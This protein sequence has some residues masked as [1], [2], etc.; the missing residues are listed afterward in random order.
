MNAGPAI[1]ASAASS[2]GE[3]FLQPYREALVACCLHPID[4]GRQCLAKR[5]ARHPALERGDTVGPPHRRPVVKLEPVAQ[6]KV[7]EQLVRGDIVI[8]YH[9]RLR[10]ELGSS[11]NSVWYTIYP[12]LRVMPAVVQIGS[13]TRR[14]YWAMKRRVFVPA[15]AALA[16]RPNPARLA[17]AVAAN[18]RRVI[19]RVILC[20][21][22]FYKLASRSNELGAQR[23]IR[24][25]GAAASDGIG[26]IAV[27]R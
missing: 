9:L 24:H 16:P 5:V 11:A 21:S 19:A 27:L 22:L 7:V 10:P 12:W 25:P 1:L 2:S 8:P 3:G 20:P 17:T 23:L 14:S 4:C 6:A 15:T 26:C 13:R 18:S